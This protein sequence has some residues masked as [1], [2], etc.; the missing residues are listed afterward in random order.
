L[1]NEIQARLFRP[2]RLWTPDEALQAE[3][4]PNAPGLYAWFFREVPAAV[5]VGGCVHQDGNTLLYVGIA[6]SRAGSRS[7]L[8]KRLRGHLRGNASGSTLRLSVGCLLSEQLGLELRRTGRSER[9]TFGQG[10][11]KLTTWLLENARLAWVEVAAPWKYE[12]SLIH[13]ASLPLNLDRNAKHPFYPELQSLRRQARQHA[14]QL[15]ALNG[16]NKPV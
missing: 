11:E 15:R 6:P 13:S 7:T 5:P 3:R 4:A 8:R 2:D 16:R 1:A 10:E 14:R 12:E 9:L